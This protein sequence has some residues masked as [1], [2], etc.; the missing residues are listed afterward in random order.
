MRVLFVD[1]RIEEVEYQWEESGCS[2]EHELLSLEPF[3]SIEQV[4]AQVRT[5]HPEVIV[6]GHGLGLF[7][8]T[9]VD[10]IKALREQGYD[11]Y[12]IANSGAGNRPFVE[13]GITING[14]AVRR[15][16]GLHIALTSLKEESR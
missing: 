6:I 10:V 15:P 5:Y 11:G 16:R 8:P 3:D 4:C 12:I 2:Q 14:N 1:D 9:G 7:K 13:A